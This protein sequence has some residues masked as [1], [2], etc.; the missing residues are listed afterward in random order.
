M[1]KVAGMPEVFEPSVE[2][3][4]AAQEAVEL[5]S[6]RDADF[7]LGVSLFERESHRPVKEVLSSDA[8][9]FLL[10]L[11][12]QVARGHRI[13][14]FDLDEELTTTE[15]AALLG[16]SRPTLVVLLKEGKIAHRMVGSHRRVSRA[17]L[18]AFRESRDT[19]PKSGRTRAERMADVSG[20]LGE[21]G[22]AEEKPSR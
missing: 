15:A 17:S 16:V 6:E 14:L 18:L 22:E 11:L 20:F 12:R 2:E 10:A 21:W 5:L 4:E 1:G 13:G 8:S 19:S 3:M 9:R 7:E